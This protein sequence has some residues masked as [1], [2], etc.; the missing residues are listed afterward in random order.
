[1]RNRLADRWEVFLALLFALTCFT[2]RPA[3]ALEVE[4]VQP[5]ALDQPRVPVL[6]RPVGGGAPLSMH[7]EM[8]GQQL[9][10]FRCYLDTG[11]TRITMSQSDSKSLGVSDTGSEVEDWGISGTETFGV[12]EPYRLCVGDSSTDITN[13]DQFGLCGRFVMQIR[14]R[15]TDVLQAMPENLTKSLTGGL[16]GM[17]GLFTVSVNV[18]GTPFLKDHVAVM[19][20]RPVAAA[21]KALGGLARGAR[22]GQ[23]S[24]DMM[25]A[26][27]MLAQ[28]G[29]GGSGRIRIHLKAESDPA[30]RTKINVP[31]VMKRVEE[32]PLPVSSA[33]AP[34]IDN[35]VL[36][37]GDRQTT[38]SLLLDTGGAVTIISPDLAHK[39]GVNLDNPDLSA[40]IMGI[41]E[42]GGKVLKGFWIDGLELPTQEREPVIYSRVPVFVADLRHLQGTI[43]V[44][45]LTPSVYLDMDMDKIARNP[46]SVFTG[47]QTGPVPF[48]RVVVDLPGGRLGLDPE[49]AGPK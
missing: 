32:K 3:G 29:S 10:A 35:V 25:S 41:G 38:A 28:Q 17:E 9:F 22:G 20:P 45:L 30:T 36:R 34:F 11:A 26:L 8:M 23:S 18:L 6:L 47:M 42:G 2:G 4:G 14:R 19:D 5:Y 7:S 40:P 24:A 21:L 44:N 43:G 33:G 39:L 12:S 15:D 1:M 49:G 37:N 31:L 46:L 48:R 27:L 13:P 16:Q